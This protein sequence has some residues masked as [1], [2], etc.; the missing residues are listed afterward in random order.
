MMEDGGKLQ[1]VFTAAH[2][3]QL[4]PRLLCRHTEAK[5]GEIRSRLFRSPRRQLKPAESHFH[6]KYLETRLQLE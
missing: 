3:P 1:H 4:Q 2:V 6:I 5:P